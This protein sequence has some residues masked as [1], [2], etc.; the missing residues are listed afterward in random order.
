MCISMVILRVITINYSYR[1]LIINFSLQFCCFD[2]ELLGG[3][4]IVQATPHLKYWGGGIYP[5]P[6]PPR[7]RHPCAKLL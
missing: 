3:G 5:P 2:G 4:M 7:D 1:A 6:H